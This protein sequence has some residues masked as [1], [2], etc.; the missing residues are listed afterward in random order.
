MLRPN[1]KKDVYLL[2]VDHNIAVDFGVLFGVV[3]AVGERH[4]GW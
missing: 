4:D 1:S 3:P 2:N